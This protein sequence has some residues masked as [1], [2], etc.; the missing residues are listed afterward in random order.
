[1][2]RA[3]GSAASVRRGVARRVPLSPSAAFSGSQFF[4]ARLEFA[5]SCG[6][7]LSASQVRDQLFFTA[8]ALTPPGAR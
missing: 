4:R 6:L 1:M 3:V 7:D 2:S 8:S 5:G